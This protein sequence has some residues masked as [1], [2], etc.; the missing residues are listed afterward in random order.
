MAAFPRPSGAV[1]E[2]RDLQALIDSAPEGSTL[3]LG[4]GRYAGGVRVGKRLTIDGRGVAIVDAQGKGSVLEVVGDGVT[5]QNLTL[6]NSGNA[7]SEVDAAI[8]VKGNFNVI[9]NNTIRGCLFGIDLSQSNNNLVRRND[10]G[11]KDVSLGL[12]GDAIRLWYSRNNEVV[13]NVVSGARDVVIWYSRDNLI[14]NN[15]IIDGR[16]GAH[17]MYA[18]ANRVEK[19]YFLRN[20]VGVF[21]MY[22]DGVSVTDNVISH[23][24]GTTGMGIGMKETSDVKI[25]GNRVVYCATGLYSDVSP[26]QPGTKNHIERNTFAYNGIGMRFH[27][28]WHG[29]IL[30]DNDF[31]ANITQVDVHGGA[32]AARNEWDG[33]YYDDYQGFDLDDDA[34]GDH[35]HEQWTFSDRLWRDLP[36]AQYFKGTPVLEVLDFLE[37][38]AP[39]SE[40][41]LVLRDHHPRI[42]PNNQVVF[43]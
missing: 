14:A 31:I 33:N 24:Q 18:K 27:T 42:G 21:L 1:V 11:S 40:P 6:V 28:D 13:E 29:S 15:T 3:R 20:S 7:H 12:R 35:S 9:R 22:S 43:Q 32:S 38:L 17:F 5:V 41:V 8:L 30:R 39:F 16:Y 37:R 25:T 2:L 19:N 36:M 34:I 4:K 10:I 26:Y 23:G